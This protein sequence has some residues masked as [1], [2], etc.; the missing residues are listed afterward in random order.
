MVVLYKYENFREVKQGRNYKA[1]LKKKA[2]QQYRKINPQVWN[3][4]EAEVNRLMI[5]YLRHQKTHYEEALEY[6]ETKEEYVLLKLMI[7]A[8]IGASFEHLSQDSCK[9]M[10][11]VIK[12]HI[13]D[14]L[15]VEEYY[16]WWQRVKRAFRALFGMQKAKA[17]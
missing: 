10:M 16:T 13:D 3:V 15:G 14:K 7:L 5:D 11:E 17:L 12:N 9:Q 2:I 1:R 6:A 4:K 8:N